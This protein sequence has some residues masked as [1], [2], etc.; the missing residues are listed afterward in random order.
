MTSVARIMGERMLA[1]ARCRGGRF[2]YCVAVVVFS[3]VA[4]ALGSTSE[5]R[6][7]AL[8]DSAVAAPDAEKASSGVRTLRV[9]KSRAMTTVSEAARIARD[10]DI[11]EIDAGDY[12]D[13]VAVWSQSDL[14]IRAASKRV[15][16]ISHG[17]AAEGKAIW[18]IK[19]DNVIVEDIEFSGLRVASR[20]GAGIRHEGARLT[21]RRCLFERNEIGLLT[22]NNPSSELEV[23]QSEFRDNAIDPPQQIEPAHQIYV[24]RIRSF[25]LRA[26]YIHR[27]AVGHLVKSRARES[28]ILYNR[29]TDESG[30]ASYEIEFPEGG[31][32]YVVGNI[33]QQSAHTEN[34]AIISFGAEGYR[35]RDNALYLVNN[36]IV[37]GLP[38]GGRYLDLAPGV[39]TVR[40]FNNLFV[41]PQTREIASIDGFGNFVIGQAEFAAGERVDFRLKAASSLV[42][43][44]VDPGEVN[45]VRIAPE[46]EYVH[47]MQARRLSRTR[48]N[49]GALQTVAR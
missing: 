15:R 38:A 6:S 3:Q 11:V 32:G 16:M 5:P 43:R 45:G 23:E 27:G 19:G 36:T 46:Y 34:P 47:P 21:V 12:L 29:I 9:G 37:D 22:G 28:R 35:H 8:P 49:P 24:G 26:S 39:A 2:R 13:D 7:A 4:L 17:A 1:H 30:H 41:G 20:N 31:V 18:V 10:G 44:A 25:A 33:I 42:G 40:A 48:Q 14:V